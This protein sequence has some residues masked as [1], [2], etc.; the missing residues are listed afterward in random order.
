MHGGRLLIGVHDD[1]A[2]GVARRAADRLD[3]TRLAAQEALLVRVKDR[4]ERHLR[5]VKP[6][7]QEVD[8]DE[9]V[10]LA[11]AQAADELHAL[12]GLHVVAGY[13]VH[14]GHE[15]AGDRRGEL[16]Q[17]DADRDDDDDRRGRYDGDVL[18]ALQKPSLCMLV[19]PAP[20][21]H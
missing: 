7:A 18:S 20:V 11:E 21:Y 14:G 3:E 12:D 9:H 19:I 10:E 13:L 6:L 17:V 1:R 5:Q 8:A 4:H 15:V 2:L 16:G